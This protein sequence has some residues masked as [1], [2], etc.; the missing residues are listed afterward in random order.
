MTEVSAD[1]DGSLVN[2]E[3]EVLR[4]P[5]LFLGW[6]LGFF[7]LFVGLSALT[8]VSVPSDFIPVLV[9]LVPGVWATAVIPF[10]GVRISEAGIRYRGLMKFRSLRWEDVA[11]VTVGIHSQG[12]LLTSV[13]P[14]VELAQGEKVE[15]TI[16]AGYARIS[17]AHNR[18]VVRQV[19]AL[20]AMRERMG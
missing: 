17:G 10:S 16:L 20:E 11:A 12:S 18:R 7:G 9:F 6:L 5:W 3:R 19:E 2:K 4:S 15:L 14:V 8:V 1:C 13:V